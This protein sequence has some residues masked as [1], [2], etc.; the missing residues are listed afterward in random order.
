MKHILVTGGNGQLA[1]CIKD[2]ENNYNSYNFIYTDYEDLDICNKTQLDSFFKAHTLAFCINCA[3]YTAVDKA[4]SETEKAYLINATG[5]KNLAE[6]CKDYNVTM[7]HVSTDFVFQGNTNQSYTENDVTKPISV[8]GASKLKGEQEIIKTLQ[9]YFI[10]RTSWLYSEHGNNFVKTM[11]RLG[12]E[13]DELKVVNDQI[14]TPTYAPDLAE[15]I[16]SFIVTKNVNYGTYHYS[17]DGVVSWFDFAASIFKL[18]KVDVK[19][20][21]IPSDHFPQDANRP[22]FSVLDKTKI[23]KELQI[24]IKPWETSLQRCLQKLI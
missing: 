13:R 2:I 14:G 24:S 4:E 23:K 19:L 20:T 17:N 5:A 12:K 3:A 16:M 1:S 15:V 6:I 9:N 21:P 7:V 11:L 10:I 8:Y 22:K 18:S